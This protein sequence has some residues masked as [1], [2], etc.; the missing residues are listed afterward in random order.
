MNSEIYEAYKPLLFTLAYRML[1][2]VMDAEDIVQDVF[3]DWEKVQAGGDRDGRPIGQVKA[4]LCRM[5]TNRAIDLLRSAKRRRERYVGVWLPEPLVS[6]SGGQAETEHNDP[7]RRLLLRDSLSMAYLVMLESLSPGER[8]VFLLREVYAYDFEEIAAMLD[9]RPDS[10]RQLLSRARRKLRRSDRA[11]ADVPLGP[12]AA[13]VAAAAE[14]ASNEQTLARFIRYVA[15]GNVEGLLGMMTDG[16]VFISDGGGKVQAAVHPIRGKDRVARLVLGIAGKQQS[17]GLTV[18]PVSVN[19]E[20]GIVVLDGDRPYCT[21][22]FA[23]ANG[24]IAAIYNMMNPDKLQHVASR[25][26]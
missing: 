6:D 21:L 8:A 15:E 22:A 11:G 14:S 12:Q 3:M 1:G 9:R 26:R 23:Y 19:G 17:A 7:L 16:A 25:V 13:Q 18:R 4:Y 24:R 20:P 10:C 5:T 2:S